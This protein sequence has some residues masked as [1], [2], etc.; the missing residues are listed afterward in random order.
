MVPSEKSEDIQV[1]ETKDRELQEIP[2]TMDMPPFYCQLCG[3][4]HPAGTPRMQCEECGRSICVDSFSDMT[5]VGRKSCPM[6]GGEMK[7][8]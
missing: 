7:V 6:C 2:K 1:T 5:K 3:E 8:L 4:R